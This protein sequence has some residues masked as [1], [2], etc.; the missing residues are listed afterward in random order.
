VS[1]IATWVTPNEPNFSTS[2]STESGST[3]P[4]NGQ[5]NATETVPT[6]R[7][8]PFAVRT[9][10]SMFSHCSPRVLFRFFL[11]CE[12]VAETSRLISFTPKPASRSSTARSTARTFAHVAL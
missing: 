1:P 9:I 6:R 10:S 11:V 12:R 2:F 4:S 8:R 3:L 7:K 5:P